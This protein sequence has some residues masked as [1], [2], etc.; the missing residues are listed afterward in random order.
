MV[1]K[2]YSIDEL[3]ELLNDE[4]IEEGV[5]GVYFH[6]VL[7]FISKYNIKDGDRPV[8]EPTLYRLYKA[9]TPNPVDKKEFAE[10]FSS[11]FVRRVSGPTKYYKL[12]TDSINLANEAFSLINEKKRGKMLTK[13]KVQAF[14]TF[15]S[16][17]NLKKGACWIEGFILFEVFKKGYTDH[18]RAVPLGYREFFNLCKLSFP[19]KR[20]TENRSLW[21]GVN[22]DIS[23]TLSEAHKE[24]VKKNRR[25]KKP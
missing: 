10:V 4:E 5:E 2:N 20:I 7:S 24:R 9:T 13:R 14:Q 17:K 1:H 12:D 22:Y 3:L 6:N 23:E 16:N 18:G 19:H 11:V 8:P 25:K 15:I 21:F